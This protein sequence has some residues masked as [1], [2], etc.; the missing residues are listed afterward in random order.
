MWTFRFV[1]KVV[2]AQGTEDSEDMWDL[3]LQQ[4][5]EA[6]VPT[7][8]GGGSYCFSLRVWKNRCSLTALFGWI[9]VWCSVK[10][11]AFI[12]KK[13]IHKLVQYVGVQSS[14]AFK[15]NS[16]H[17]VAKFHIFFNFFRVRLKP[18]KKTKCRWNTDKLILKKPNSLRANINL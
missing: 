15:A 1:H 6:M 8:H 16:L 2:V 12:W 13:M 14:N 4:S 10:H 3:L 9:F 18:W 17:K 5:G 11:K 7:N